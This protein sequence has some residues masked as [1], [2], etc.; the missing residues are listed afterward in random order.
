MINCYD[1]VRSTMSIILVKFEFR[2]ENQKKAWIGTLIVLTG[3]SIA[4]CLS[5]RY[6]LT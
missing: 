4:P 5:M 6:Y 3:R 2:V 1:K